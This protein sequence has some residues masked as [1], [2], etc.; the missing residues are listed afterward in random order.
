MRLLLDPKNEELADIPQHATTDNIDITAR[1]VARRHSTLKNPSAFTRN[2]GLEAR[3]SLRPRHSSKEYA[4]SSQE[5]GRAA[6]LNQAA[7][8]R[9]GHQAAGSPAHAY[10]GSP[11]RPHPRGS[12]GRRRPALQ[13]F[14]RD[15]KAVGDAVHSLSAANAERP[16]THLPFARR[17]DVRR[18]GRLTGR[19]RPAWVEFLQQIHN[20]FAQQTS[21]DSRRQST[22]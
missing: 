13:R 6:S 20:A 8:Y 16:V 18:N 17:Q 7:G 15:Y 5:V 21:T 11:R 14:W 4:K 1:E 12:N 22:T 3:S 19:S 10:G 9:Q 2:E